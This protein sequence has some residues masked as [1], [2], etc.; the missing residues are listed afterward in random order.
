MITLLG[1]LCGAS[2]INQ[3]FERLLLERLQDETYLIKNGKTL[4]S[5]VEA[6]SIVFENGEKRSIDTEDKYS[7]LDT[8]WIDDLKANRQKGFQQ[9]RIILTRY[10]S[11]H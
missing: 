11:N 4:E 10:V 9:N 3:R 8:I 2:F 7:E 1:E 6:L 5:I